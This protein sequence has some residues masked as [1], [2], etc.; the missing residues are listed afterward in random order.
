MTFCNYGRR[1]AQMHVKMSFA[2]EERGSILGYVT[3]RTT[4][5]KARDFPGIKAKKMV[6]GPGIEPGTRGFSVLC[7]TY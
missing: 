1:F 3:E 2:K 5:G 7:S 4:T 6:A